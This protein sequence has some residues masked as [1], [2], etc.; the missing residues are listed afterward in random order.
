MRDYLAGGGRLARLRDF[1]PHGARSRRGRRVERQT[2]VG[3]R[4]PRRRS[5]TSSGVRCLPAQPPDRRGH[6]RRRRR[7]GSADAGAV[8]WSV[9]AD[10]LAGEGHSTGRLYGEMRAECRRAPGR[11]SGSRRA[12]RRSPTLPAI[13]S[14]G[15][16]ASR[17]CG[18]STTDGLAARRS[19]RR[20][21]T[22][23]R[24][25]AGFGRC[26]SSMPGRRRA[27]G[28][29]L[30]QGAGGGGRG[31]VGLR[32]AA[33]IRSQ[34]PAHPRRPAA[35]CDSTSSC[36]RH[37]D[38]PDCVAPCRCWRSLSR[39][40]CGGLGEAGES[41][42]AAP[43]GA[44]GPAPTRRQGLG[45]ATARVVRLASRLLEIRARR[46]RHRHRHRASI[47]PTP[48]E[49]GA[50][51]VVPPDMADTARPPS[52]AVGAAVVAEDVD[53]GISG[54]QRQVVAGGDGPRR[55]RRDGSTRGHIHCD[56]YGCTLTSRGSFTA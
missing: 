40:A 15:W 17:P 51:P 10:V 2:S 36:R 37:G 7:C 52:A 19:G 30:Q 39:T 3:R 43:R 13:R 48:V 32:R 34:P 8:R 14:S 27:R 45:G 35:R 26:C 31:L 50:Y 49:A 23:R 47:R 56:R 41:P 55:L 54:R 12:S 29:L 25:A 53:H 24:S 18:A 44:S 46:R 6:L 21:W 5:T 20:S 28:S 33:A 16:A 9:T 42:G 1:A 4:R 11:R 22:S 38:R